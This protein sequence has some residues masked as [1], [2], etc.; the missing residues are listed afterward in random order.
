[1]WEDIKGEPD[2]WLRTQTATEGGEG[3]GAS[4]PPAHVVS[5]HTL[6]MA[7][8]RAGQ[9]RQHRARGSWLGKASRLSCGL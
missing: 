6:Q 4:V 5:P 3:D 1:M 9:G 7:R 2:K 8:A